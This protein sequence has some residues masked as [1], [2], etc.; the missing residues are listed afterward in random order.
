MFQTSTACLDHLFLTLCR[1][2]IFPPRW[3]MC[4]VRKQGFLCLSLSLKYSW[5][6]GRIPALSFTPF[7]QLPREIKLSLKYHKS[8]PQ[9]IIKIHTE[10]QSGKAFQVS[11]LTSLSSAQSAQYFHLHR[12][13][14]WLM[15][16]YRSGKKLWRIRP[17]FKMIWWCSCP[18]STRLI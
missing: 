6:R 2:H 16:S 13:I 17:N 1:K 5:A 9:L 11:C 4:L 12:A 14:K 10:R 18:K 3:D 15:I 8:G 7:P